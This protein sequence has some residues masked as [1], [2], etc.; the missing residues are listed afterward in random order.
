MNKIVLIVAFFF[1]NARQY[2]NP[3]STM[4][5]EHSYWMTHISDVALVVRQYTTV[6][7]IF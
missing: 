1:T 3:F 6:E 7:D 4:V 2:P 5:E